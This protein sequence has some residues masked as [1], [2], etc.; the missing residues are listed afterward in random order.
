MKQLGY[1][2]ILKYWTVYVRDTAHK[3]VFPKFI[4]TELAKDILHVVEMESAE[5]EKEISQEMT[6][7]NN[8]IE[9]EVVFKLKEIIN[10]KNDPSQKPTDVFNAIRQLI[11]NDQDTEKALLGDIMRIEKLLAK[12]GPLDESKV[13]FELKESATARIS[14]FQK[15]A[16]VNKLQTEST[17]GSPP[18]KPSH[19]HQS[20]HLQI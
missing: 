13:S 10:A 6:R 18:L 14:S 17:K 4:A 20:L 8:V 15:K 2:T 11:H 7:M 3:I 1:V 16:V 9:T 19:L 5:I 12:Q